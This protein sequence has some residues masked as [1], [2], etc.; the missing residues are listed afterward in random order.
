MR[1]RHLVAQVASETEVDQHR[2]EVVADEDV[3]RLHIAVDDAFFVRCVESVGNFREQ[4]HH[5]TAIARRTSHVFAAHLV[6]LQVDLA[7]QHRQWLDLLEV[8]CRWRRDLGEQELELDAVDAVH[9]KHARAVRLHFMVAISNDRFMA[10]RLQ[11][12]ALLLKPFSGRLSHASHELHRYRSPIRREPG[13]GHAHATRAEHS[14][15]L[16]AEH[17][18]AR[19]VK[20][21]AARRLPRSQ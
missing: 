10:K 9:D 13:I 21:T 17:R 7:E 6:R 8:A 14:L 15:Q 5:A 3:C 19:Q 2:R 20:Q 1:E 12:P 18:R 4:A 11:Q 16:A